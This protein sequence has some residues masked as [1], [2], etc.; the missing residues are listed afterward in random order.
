MI[1][2]LKHLKNCVSEHQVLNMQSRKNKVLKNNKHI[3][4]EFA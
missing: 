1:C 2:L 4:M 3:V